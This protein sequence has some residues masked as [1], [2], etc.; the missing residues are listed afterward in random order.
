MC[1]SADCGDGGAAGG[2]DGSSEPALALSMCGGLI[3]ALSV[4]NGVDCGDG[5][6][7]GGGDGSS[8]PDLALSMR[9][10][11]IA[12]LSVGNGVDCGDGGAA[13]DCNG[14]GEPAASVA[15]FCT[16]CF[17]L[18]R[19]IDNININKLLTVANKIMTKF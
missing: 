7:A 19:Y 5:G 14:S 10:G 13:G 18:N 8:E 3:A 12:A 17:L 16:D 9:G 4:G 11:L 15:A 6:A 2:G 1:N